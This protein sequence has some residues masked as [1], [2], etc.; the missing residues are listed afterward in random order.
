MKLRK[1]CTF[2]LIGTLILGGISIPTYATSAPGNEFTMPYAF[3]SLN[4]R[5]YSDSILLINPKLSL[6]T[7]DKVTFDCNY[8]PTSASVDFGVVAPNGKFYSL[9]STDGSIHRSIT[10]NQR[11]Q[12]TLL[13][14]NNESY[15]ITVAGEVNY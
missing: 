4:H 8:V 2:L 6:N 15:A 10:V 7:G 13:I 1:W 11:G 9:N 12:Y 14:R 3:G 5:I